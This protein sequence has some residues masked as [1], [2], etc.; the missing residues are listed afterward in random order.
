LIVMKFGGSSVADADR[1]RAVAEIVRGRLDRRPVIV[2]SALAGVTDLLEQAFAAA[3]AGDLDGLEPLLADIERRHRWA[4]TGCIEDA[5]RRHRLGLEI[6]RQFDQLRQRLRSVRIL[7]EGTPRVRDAVL[8]HGETLSARIV[9]AAFV[10]CGLP[11]R[12][13]DPEQVMA[14]DDRF[15]A[16]SPDPT[17]VRELCRA[18][19]LPLLEA[20]ELPV[21]GGFIGSSG[22]GET[23]TLGRGG[24]D[25]SASVIGMAVEADEIQIW[26]D[27][28]GLMSADPRLVPAARTLRRVSFVEAA[29]LAL[30]GARVLHPDS[31]APAVHRRIPVRVLNSM[32]PEGEGTLIVGEQPT[33][34]GNPVAVASK[35]G[36]GIVRVS[37]GRLP[38]D[39]VLPQRVLSWSA[40]AG[41]V[42]EMVVSSA[43]TVTL[44]ASWPDR[45]DRI[46]S[47]G[48]DAVVDI[49]EDRAIVCVVGGALARVPSLAERVLAELTRWGPELITWGALRAGVLAVMR[50]T[51]LA[52]SVRCLHEVFL[53]GGPRS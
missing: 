12:V 9:S 16:A 26:T 30:Y 32:S 24:S 5:G 13:V 2:V 22:A 4:L 10:E 47:F 43:T 21:V 29:E 1:I 44:V 28:D 27:V 40:E 41:I 20:A 7:G 14:T 11:S 46:G 31:I 53:E 33:D 34:E 25:T 39:P 42:P 17:R 18:S 8:A 15:G 48:D 52:E 3:R 45:L 50:R 38:M 51:S 6:D 23:T 37:S 35:D 19:L 36:I 49:S